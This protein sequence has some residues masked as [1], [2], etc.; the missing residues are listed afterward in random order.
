M[1]SWICLQV[2]QMVL[3]AIGFA[4][5]GTGLFFLTCGDNQKSRV[6]GLILSLVCALIIWLALTATYIVGGG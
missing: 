1:N 6:F 5:G 3:S 2:W 4:L